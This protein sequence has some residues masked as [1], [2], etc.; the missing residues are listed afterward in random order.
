MHTP[1]RVG[2][3]FFP[4]KERQNKAVNNQSKHSNNPRWP[5]TYRIFAAR[6]RHF[7]RFQCNVAFRELFVKTIKHNFLL[8]LDFVQC[9]H[10]IVTECNNL[11]IFIKARKAISLQLSAGV[12]KRK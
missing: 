10:Q 4:G 5:I 7:G 1:T 11:A 8:F 9:H 3:G 2:M 12:A 6:R